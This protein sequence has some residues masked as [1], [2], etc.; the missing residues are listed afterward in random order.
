MKKV[1]T[2]QASTSKARE[3]NDDEYAYEDLRS[4]TSNSNDDIDK[5]S[6]PRFKEVKDMT[7]YKWVWMLIGR[8]PNDQMLPVAFDVVEVESKDTWTWA[9]ADQSCDALL[10]NMSETFNSVILQFREKPIVTMLEEIRMSLMDR[11]A[12]NRTKILANPKS[13]FLRIKAQ[14]EKQISMSGK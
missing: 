14:P 6:Y 10:N 5:A 3:F 1:V 13:I 2:A 4:A 12:N 9:T 11:W 7:N 8:D